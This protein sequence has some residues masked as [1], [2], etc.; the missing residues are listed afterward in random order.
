MSELL[1]QL[2][3]GGL[4]GA[5]VAFCGLAVFGIAWTAIDLLLLAWRLVRP[6][7]GANANRPAARKH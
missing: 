7:G 4:F 6:D 5:F 3:V 2:L 1:V